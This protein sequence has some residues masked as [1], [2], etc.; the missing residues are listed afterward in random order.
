MTDECESKTEKDTEARVTDKIMT[1]IAESSKISRI[2]GFLGTWPPQEGQPFAI[3]TPSIRSLIEAAI[4][5]DEVEIVQFLT[6]RGTYSNDLLIFAAKHDNHCFHTISCYASD[7]ELQ[8]LL[9]SGPAIS[10]D[11]RS[12]VEMNLSIHNM[13]KII[14]KRARKD[15]PK[16]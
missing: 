11:H 9:D 12:T 1:I 8:S 3:S 6:T 4:L 16:S 15:T 5:A 14:A 7:S 2:Q 13:N 10:S